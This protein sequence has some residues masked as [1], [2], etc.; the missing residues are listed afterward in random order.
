VV[1]G[2]VAGL[3]AAQGL[4]RHGLSVALLEA[5]DRLGGRIAT[6]HTPGS[7]VPLEL[8]A[9][10]VHGTP[11]EILS[12]PA[13]HFAL[14]EIHGETWTFQPGHPRPDHDWGERLERMLGEISAWRGADRSLAHFLDERFPEEQ[15]AA[16]RRAIRAYIEGFDAADT[17]DV[18]MQW[19]ALTARAAQ[20]SGEGRQFRLSS[21]Y[22]RLV[23][24][25][26]DSLPADRATI[27][28]NTI[29][30][31][32][33]WSPGHVR[34]ESHA[35]SGELL[36]AVTAQAA[37]IALPLGVLTASEDDVATVRFVPELQDK[38]PAYQHLAMGHVV[39]VVL[40][41]RDD[42]WERLNR[43]YPRMPWLSFLLA[44]DETIPTW[45]TS[46]PL[47]APLLTG[48]VGGPRAAQVSQADSR[49]VEQAVETLARMLHVPP[50]ELEAGLESWH[51]HNWRNDPFA[52][53]AYS[54][55]RV[56]G[57]DAPRQLGEPMADTLFFAGEA[58]D[59][60]GQTGTVHAAIASGNR[61][62]R[63]IL[64]SR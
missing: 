34:V 18:S 1:G 36:D 9:E 44:T 32:I 62:V 59:T 16:D 43:R 37:V 17:H 39:K 46:Y 21:G 53:G 54:Y 5:R 7:I 26:Q 2:G 51:M 33:Q 31:E 42:F 35:P 24:W 48:W 22:G 63:E 3:T 27:R 58:T 61:V 55:V 11:P 28:L 20:R 60:E 12:L 13:S 8:G 52:R 19:L 6:I 41:F 23:D 25:L 45:W 29:V 50:K 10:F 38:Q 56:G 57:L 4:A 64:R 30:Q 15:Q 49:I 14:Y 47:V 40:R